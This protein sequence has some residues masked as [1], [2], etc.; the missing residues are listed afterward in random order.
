MLEF[1][2]TLD[3]LRR[4]LKALRERANPRAAGG[5]ETDGGALPDERPPHY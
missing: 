5:G 2:R 3:G 4:E 1:S